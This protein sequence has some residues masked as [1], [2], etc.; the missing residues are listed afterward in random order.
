MELEYYILEED[1]GNNTDA[2]K[3]FHRDCRKLIK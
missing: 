1:V 3:A 2:E